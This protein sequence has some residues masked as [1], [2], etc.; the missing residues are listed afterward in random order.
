MHE[1][2]L[3]MVLVQLI[4]MTCLEEVMVPTEVMKG[5]IIPRIRTGIL[6]MSPACPIQEIKVMMQLHI[7]TKAL[8]CFKCNCE[9]R[10]RWMILKLFSV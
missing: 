4:E 8:G 3:A 6:V 1:S 5:T 9:G 2:N 7:G 10:V